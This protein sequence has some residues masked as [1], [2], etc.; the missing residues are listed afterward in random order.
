MPIKSTKKTTKSIIKKPT[1]AEQI[2]ID[3]AIKQEEKIADERASKELFT[4]RLTRNE[5]CHLRD[6]LGVRLPP[7]FESTLSEE[8]AQR[9]QRVVTETNLW[10]K[11]GRVCEEANIALGDDAPDFVL[12]V[13][14]PAPIGV[15]EIQGDPN[16]VEEQDEDNTD[17]SQLFT[18]KKK[19]D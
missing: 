4:L 12:G 8:L 5:L 7:T 18:G 15:F 1:K 9:Q 11:L 17:A 16:Y 14:G 13:S 6:V 2:V 3:A 10:S 19:D